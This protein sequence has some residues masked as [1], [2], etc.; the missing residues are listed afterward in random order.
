MKKIVTL[1][2]F[3]LGLSGCQLQPASLATDQVNAVIGNASYVAATGQLPTTSTPDEARV[4][5]HLA[6]AERLLRQKSTTGLSPT[7]AQRRANLLDKLHAYWQAG[8]FPRNHD[9]PSERRPC[10]IDRDGRLCAVGFLVAETAG[11]PVAERINQQ[12]KYDLITAMRTPA[13]AAWVQSSG[14]T[15]AECALI[16]PTYGSPVTLG[17]ATAVP[18]QTSYGIGSAMWSGVNVMLGLANA[19]QFNQPNAGR[20]AAYVGLVSGT[21]QALLGALHLPA[22]MPPITGINSILPG[23]SYAAERTV[24]FLNIG[25]GTATLAVSAWNLLHHRNATV[26]RTEVGLVNYPGSAGGT[27]LSLTR[28]F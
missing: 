6:Y 16:Q 24:S 14:L 13:L 20:G 7:L 21:A 1:L 25:A 22:D 17:S 2:L 11:R 9:Y 18:V 28:R 23:K 8:V 12:H 19:S 3:V 4:Q 5:A 15:L 27:G 26:E 10:F